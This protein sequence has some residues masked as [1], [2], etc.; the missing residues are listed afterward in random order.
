MK[1]TVVFTK[2]VDLEERAS[3]S[4]ENRNNFCRRIVCGQVNFYYISCCILSRLRTKHFY[5][6]NAYI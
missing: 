2:I 4:H 5:Y 6:D 3:F 1:F